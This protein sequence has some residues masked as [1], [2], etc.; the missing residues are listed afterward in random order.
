MDE[1]S[2]TVGFLGLD[3]DFNDQPDVHC[4]QLSTLRDAGRPILAYV[5]VV[6]KVDGAENRYRRVDFAEVN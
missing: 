2:K 3:E 6:T 1:R 4:L 5:L